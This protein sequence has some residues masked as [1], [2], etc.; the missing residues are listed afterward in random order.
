MAWWFMMQVILFLP[1]NYK[2][3]MITKFGSFQTISGKYE[4]TLLT[5]AR[6]AAAGVNFLLHQSCTPCRRYLENCQAI[7]LT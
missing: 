2:P 4:W 5:D 3:Y 6:Q 1:I 7:R